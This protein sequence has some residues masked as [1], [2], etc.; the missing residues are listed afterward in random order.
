MLNL[1]LYSCRTEFEIFNE[2]QPWSVRHTVWH[3]INSR[4]LH[5]DI[6][7]SRNLGAE[8]RTL[9]FR[10]CDLVDNIVGNEYSLS[11]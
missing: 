3:C 9:T 4:K 10:D 7:Y 6:K 11:D 2:N 5:L 8:C 1:S